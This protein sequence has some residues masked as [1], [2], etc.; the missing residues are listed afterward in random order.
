MPLIAVANQKGGVGKTTTVVSLAS[1]LQAAGKRVL[2]VDNDPQSNLALA[3]GIPETDDLFPT[4]G[5][6]LM[7]AT[8]SQR[9]ASIRDAIVHTPS[10]LDLVPSN[11]QLSAAEL[12][13]V[14]AFGRE[15]L[16]KKLLDEVAS[17][18]DYILIDCLPSLGLLAVNALTAADGVLIP[19]QS[20]F[21]AVQGLAQIMDTVAAVREKLNPELRILGVLL[22][23]VDPRT[24]HSREVSSLLRRTLGIE[25]RVFDAEIRL[26]VALKDAVRSGQPVRDYS[27]RSQAA[28]AYQDLAY[29]VMGIFGDEPDYDRLAAAGAGER[30]VR[31]Q[32]VVAEW[33]SPVPSSP[34]AEDQPEDESEETLLSPSLADEIAARL[35]GQA[36]PPK[37]S[38]VA[39]ATSSV[40][41]V[42]AA[43]A[44]TPAEPTSGVPL[45]R[46]FLAGRE[47]W[48]GPPRT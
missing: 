40:A 11:V 3:L 39:A 25:L 22:T 5:D 10:G 8:R 44:L 29:E 9:A 34:S 14:A 37:P 33:G 24:S 27:P 17:E 21:L 15:H 32:P 18:Y 35:L 7:S 28:Q 13:L 41:S 16:M 23:M 45:F 38:A 48:L 20:D 26:Q 47:E 1:A 36:E 42:P 43:T 30:P 46:K 2:V 19:V 6:L 12:V 4:L 31:S